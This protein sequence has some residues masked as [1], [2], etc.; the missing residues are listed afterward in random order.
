MK[1]KFFFTFIFLICQIF[2]CQLSYGVET[3]K[4]E[5]IVKLSP[6][7]SIANF[8]NS[9][10]IPIQYN[11]ISTNLGYYLLTA[12]MASDDSFLQI[13]KNKLGVIYAQLNHKVSNRSFEPNDSLLSRQWHYSPFDMPNRGRTD[14]NIN[15]AW[16]KTSTVV[17][18][19]G[20]TLVIAVIDDGFDRLHPDINYYTNYAEIPNNEIDDDNNGYVDDDLGW[21]IFNNSSNLSFKSHGTKV[22]GVAGGITNNKIGIAGVGRGTKVLAIEGSA[23]RESDVIKAYNYVFEQRRLYNTTNGSIGAYIIACN[24]SFGVDNGKA[25]NFPIWCDMLY[26]L[27]EVG[28]VSTIAVTNLKINLDKRNDIPTDCLTPLQINVA[29]HDREGSMGAYGKEKVDL[30]APGVNVLTTTAAGSK[31]TSDNG[32]SFA[33]P[34]VAGALAFLYAYNCD[35]ILRYNA[36][37]PKEVATVFRTRLLKSANKTTYNDTLVKY[38]FLDVSQPLEDLLI[39][40][41]NPAVRDS[42]IREEQRQDSIKRAQFIEDSI[43]RAI[44]VRDSIRRVDSLYADSL[45]SKSFEVL[46]LYPNPT[47]GEI[48]VDLYLSGGDLSI[49]ILNISGKEVESLM[50]QDNKDVRQKIRLSNLADMPEGVYLVRF[51]HS[52]GKQITKRLIKIE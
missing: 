9:F 13:L 28:I 32:T 35:S 47:T 30:S 27:G 24:T 5:F 15:Q 4:G 52:N 2:Y 48:N 7:V 46:N 33:A 17:S 12:E 42:I 31:Y 23:I 3:Y 29:R 19:L 43:A 10:N 16:D 44:F 37:N 49:S 50:I 8:V 25:E 40:D 34:M 26:N 20:D 14:I 41:C 38:G 18:S 39:Q 51:M 36:D 11:A 21:N 6:K 22:V 45:A 1:H